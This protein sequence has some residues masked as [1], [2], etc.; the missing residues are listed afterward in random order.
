M[1]EAD[2]SSVEYQRMMWELLRKSINGIVNK[3]NI[4]NIQMVV[5]ELLNENI[6]RGRGLLA[7]AIIKSQMASPNFTHVYSALISVINSKLPSIGELIINRVLIQFK[8]SYERNNRIV[9]MATTKMIA[10]L[11]NQR[12]LGEYVALQVL[13]TLLMN[14]SE[15][16]V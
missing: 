14:V 9:C 3:V 15:D 13:M 5:I 4:S 8:R 12:I 11:V 16:S 1:L 10:H 2:H 7:R 6:I